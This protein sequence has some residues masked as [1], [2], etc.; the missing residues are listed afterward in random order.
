MVL[1][2]VPVEYTMK[3]RNTTAHA[4][5]D[6][7]SRLPLPV[8]PAISKLPQSWFYL[9]TIYLTHLLLQIKSVTAP[10]RI[11]S[12][13]RLFSSCSKDG[14]VRVR[15]R[16]YFPPFTRRGWNCRCMKVVCCGET[17]L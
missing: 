10:G 6:V 17:V 5:E 8:E 13:P 12:Y 11:P 3:F 7:L 2:H 4:N 16:M 9:L 15:L 14:Q 1:V